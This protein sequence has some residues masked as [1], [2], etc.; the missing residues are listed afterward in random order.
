[1]ALIKIQGKTILEGKTIFSGAG[2]SV[3]DTDAAAYVANVEA[4]DGDSLENSVKLAIDNFVLGCKTDGIW[5]ALK[6][7]CILAGAKTL[8]GALVPLVGTAPTNFNFVS[9]D[10]DRETGLKGNGSTK[11]LNA[12]RSANDDPQNNT[13]ISV[14]QKEAFSGVRSLIGLWR[15]TSPYHHFGHIITNGAQYFPR[16]QSST[17]SMTVQG[18][19]NT[20]GLFGASRSSGSS[21]QAKSGTGSVNTINVTSS[22]TIGYNYYVFAA[23]DAGTLA[24]PFGGRL[25]FY[26]IGEAIDLALLN[27]RVST[28]MTDIAAA[29]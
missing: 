4:A 20:V 24:V 16:L 10:Y 1:M 12:N 19:G 2:Y 17:S 26:S 6:A 7:S 29:I 9:G 25:S 13:H 27:T 3:Q 14:Y 21:Y 22:A 28:L 15:Q 8:N 11:Y 23:N 5:S 18:G